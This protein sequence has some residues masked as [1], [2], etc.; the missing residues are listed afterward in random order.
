MSGLVLLIIGLASLALV[1]AMLAFCTLKGWRVY[2]RALGVSRDL[3]PFAGQ[4]SAWSG[5]LEMKA[6][7]LAQ[8][9]VEISANIERL[10]TSM[11]R[12]QVVAEAFNESTEPYR[13]L[14]RYLGV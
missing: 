2:Q 12:L 4:L 10:Q 7:R 6:E 11:R 8:N 14:R 9:A 5:V 3:T 1:V 13:R